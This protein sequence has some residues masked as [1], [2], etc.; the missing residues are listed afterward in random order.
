MDN[1]TEIVLIAAGGGGVFGVFLTALF[2]YL[3]ARLQIRTR[4]ERAVELSQKYLSL[5]DMTADQLEERI[6]LIGKLDNENRELRRD[7]SEVKTKQADRDEQM[8]ALQAHIAALQEQSAKDAEERQALRRIIEEK[9][10]LLQE[11][12]EYFS[13]LVHYFETHNLHDYPVPKDELLD[14][15]TRIR[16]KRRKR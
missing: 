8:E 12:K 6:N 1:V 15:N 4:E 5:N 2:N 7:L 14:T 9:D 13:N 10:K 11:V 16:L 3:T